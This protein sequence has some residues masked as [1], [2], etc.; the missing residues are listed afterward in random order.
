[1]RR[2]GDS[3]RSTWVPHNRWRRQPSSPL[4]PRHRP[5]HF[6]QT[7]GNLP[8][9]QQHR[10]DRSVVLGADAFLDHAHLRYSSLH[11]AYNHLIRVGNIRKADWPKLVTIEIRTNESQSEGNHITDPEQLSELSGERVEELALEDTQMQHQ[12]N[13]VSFVAKM[14]TAILKKFCKAEVIQGS[15]GRS[16]STKWAGKTGGKGDSKNW[17]NIP[18]LD[19]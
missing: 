5:H 8:L 16:A 4:H 6:S 14:Q 18:T 10:V 2:S 7:P 19:K 13:D 1:M 15:K 17:T 9:Q 12:C 11:S 3:P